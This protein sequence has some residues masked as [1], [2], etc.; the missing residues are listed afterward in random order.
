MTSNASFGVRFT[1]SWVAFY[2]RSLDEPVGERRRAEMASDLW[3]QLNDASSGRASAQV[4]DRCLRGIPADVWWRYRTLLESRGIRERSRGMYSNLRQNWWQALVVAQAIL[5]A[6]FMAGV[7]IVAPDQTE[8][9]TIFRA[10]VSTIGLVSATLLIGGLVKQR[11][12]RS[13]GSRLILVGSLSSLLTV[14][15]LNP[16]GFI[17]IAVIATG[18]W[19]GNLAFNARPAEIDTDHLTSRG[20]SVGGT[21][22]YWWLITAAALAGV[23]FLAVLTAELVNV[24]D[25]FAGV[26]LFLRVAPQLGRRRPGSSHRRDAWCEALP[27]SPPHAVSLNVPTDA[28]APVCT[29]PLGPTFEGPRNAPQ[30]GPADPYPCRDSVI[31]RE[32]SPDL[33]TANP[34]GQ[35]H[36]THHI[37]AR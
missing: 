36:R 11:T 10:V 34:H 25:G 7:A 35:T 33:G 26:V 28:T 19:T 15:A 20:L 13:V 1:R 9:A 17:A 16:A 31:P 14:I 2:T 18:L 24:S 22:W 3:E 29:R 23:G 27:S 6:A 21:R 37:G 12:N 8:P 5:G 32:R 4:L 30:P